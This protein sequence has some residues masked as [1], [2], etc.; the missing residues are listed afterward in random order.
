MSEETQ[1][2]FLKPQRPS[3]TWHIT[4]QSVT[5]AVSLME[6][7]AQADKLKALGRRVSNAPGAVRAARPPSTCALPQRRPGCDPGPRCGC[8]AVQAHSLVPPHELLLAPG[9]AQPATRPP[10]SSHV[11]RCLHRSGPQAAR[12]A[13]RT[14]R[15]PAT[16]AQ[17]QA[18][19]P[20]PDTWPAGRRSMQRQTRAGRRLRPRAFEEDQL[21]GALHVAPGRPASMPAS[22]LCAAAATQRVTGTPGRHAG[23]LPLSLASA[24]P[25][26]QREHARLCT[27]HN[28]HIS[29]KPN[30]GPACF[31]ALISQARYISYI[32]C[33]R[34]V[35]VHTSGCN[36]GVPSATPQQNYAAADTALGKRTYW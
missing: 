13:R 36:A 10:W 20:A 1:L 11:R 22:R 7:A 8:L 9:A 24:R 23:C 3:Q 25:R 17:Q 34:A 19:G 4:E 31:Y 29:S 6:A 14:K 21:A 26:L 12:V 15:L 2:C 33:H 35:P 18:P 28:A 27:C 5:S 16:P 32:F 30:T